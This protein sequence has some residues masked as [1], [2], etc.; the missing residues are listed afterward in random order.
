V[1]DAEEQRA[2]IAVFVADLGLPMTYPEGA[3]PEVAAKVR[4]ERLDLE[5]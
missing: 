4:V 5:T 2:E 1:A 3:A